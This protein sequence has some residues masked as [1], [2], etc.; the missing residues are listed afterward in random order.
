MDNQYNCLRQLWEKTLADDF[1]YCGFS[2]DPEGY[3]VD[4]INDDEPANT[5]NK[6]QNESSKND[7]ITLLEMERDKTFQGINYYP[8]EEIDAINE[9]IKIIKER[10]SKWDR[11]IKLWDKMNSFTK[12]ISEDFNK[13]QQK[14]NSTIAGNKKILADINK[15]IKQ[16]FDAI[17]ELNKICDG[18]EKDISKER[19]TRLLS[20]SKETN[21]NKYS[22]KTTYYT[23][24]NTYEFL[25]KVFN[26]DHRCET[27]YMCLLSALESKIFLHNKADSLI[28]NLE[29]SFDIHFLGNFSKCKYDICFEDR[30]IMQKSSGE[31]ANMLLDI[32]FEKII[33][34]VSEHKDTILIIDQPE[35]NLDNRN[36]KGKIVD[37]VKEMKTNNKLPQ[38]IFVSHNPNVTISAD[39]ENI[40]IAEKDKENKMCHYRN[41]GIENKEFS[42]EVCNVLEG[43]AEAL[44][45]RGIKFSVTFQK[46]Y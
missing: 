42:K 29:K 20:M 16:I 10:N 39:S 30:S 4:S 9:V 33:K 37:R 32:M 19:F 44:R 24:L 15:N 43:G 28:I 14:K 18:I 7:L 12:K 26:K 34:S 40:I 6:N 27:L 38:V 21:F 3:E 2:N 13:L 22:L 23:G 36:I 25:N 11:N 1:S 45:Q 35:D 46:K 31:K 5:S 41:G 17:K 8:L